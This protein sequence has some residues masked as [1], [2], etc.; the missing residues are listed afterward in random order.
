MDKTKY[1][2]IF[3]DCHLVDGDNGYLIYD[4]K[5]CK[6]HSIS[7]KAYH[8]LKEIDGKK[9]SSIVSK[10]G[11]G[12]NKIIDYYISEEICFLTNSPDSFPKIS[13]DVH[14]DNECY[15]AI[16]EIGKSAK[17]DYLKVINELNELGCQMLMLSIKST[18][19]ITFEE[20]LKIFD[21]IS[22]SFLRVIDVVV[23]ISFEK[24]FS[25][26]FVNQN[27]R[28]SSI[29]YLSS[30]QLKTLRTDSRVF[31]NWILDEELNWTEKVV[32]KNFTF[33]LKSYMESKK[34]NVALNRKI[35]IDE[36]GFI[37]NYLNHEEHFGNLSDASTSI[38]HIF[39]SSKF[40]KKWKISNDLID[41]CELCKYRYCC[42]S[43]TDLKYS[44]RKWH[45]LNPCQD[46]EYLREGKD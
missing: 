12:I 6:L 31:I 45:K 38:K 37:R 22:D 4:L 32:R 26:D 16:I 23:P 33:S 19:D 29:T 41:K 14:F 28:I 46:F 2:K 15:S 25:E 13:E 42:F 11:S 20:I 27:I 30:V 39:R 9:L 40:Q 8:L 5:R 34:Y 10:F 1:L 7:R 36:F 3:T 43:N 35:C 18:S 17:Y 21:T 44:N 24:M